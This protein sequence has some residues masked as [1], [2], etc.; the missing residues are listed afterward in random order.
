MLFARFRGEG[1]DKVAFSDGWQPFSEDVQRLRE[2]ALSTA[3]TS[4]RRHPSL[5]R[6]T[7][8]PSNQIRLWPHRLARFSCTQHQ[9]ER[10]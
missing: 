8:F 3:R 10:P 7:R 6:P 5:S 1:V 4:L 2:T 9:T